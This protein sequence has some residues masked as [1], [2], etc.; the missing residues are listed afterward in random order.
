MAWQPNM[1][2]YDFIFIVQSETQ[3]KI[4]IIET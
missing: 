4:F 1:T 2:T 3:D